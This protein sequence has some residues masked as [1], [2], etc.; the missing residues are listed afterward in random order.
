MNSIKNYKLYKDKS[1]ILHILEAFIAVLIV[2]SVVLILI[3]R[4]KVEVIKSEEI[5]SL[6]KQ[7]LDYVKVDEELRS[8]ILIKNSSGVNVLIEKTVP[9]WINYSINICDANLVCPNLAGILSQQVYANELLITANRTYYPG[10]A[11]RIVLFF[12]EK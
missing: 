5:I 6:Q 4:Q 11:T 2:L 9:V 12:W 1:A 8:Q 3:S 7:I 10:N